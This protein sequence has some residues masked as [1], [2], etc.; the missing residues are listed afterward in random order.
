MVR[1]GKKKGYSKN[2]IDENP[3]IEEPT[4]IRI[5]KIID[6]FFQ[7]TDQVYTFEAGLTNPERAVVHMLCR[8]RGLVS[9]STGKGKQRR[10]SICKSKIKKL[11]ARKE[12]KN[13]T[14]LA[15]SEETKEVLRDLFTR[16]PPSD[17][18]QK[19]QMLTDHIREVD[20]KLRKK[21]DSFY[22]PSMS[23]AEIAKEMKA[24]AF[25][26]KNTPKLRQIDGERSKLPIASFREAI[27]STIETNQ[28]VL[29]SGETG[30]GKTTQ[31]PQYLLDYMWGKGEA[32]K[33][34]CTQP[35]RISATS[36]A[37]RISYERGEKV[38]ESIGY[39]I[40]LETKGGKRSSI[41][42]CTNGILLRVLVGKGTND[43]KTASEDISSKESIFGVTHII[44]RRAPLTSSSTSGKFCLELPCLYIEQILMSATL[45]AERFSQYFGGCPVIRVPGFTHPVKNF[46]LEDILSILK[47]SESN[48]LDSLSPN[49]TVQGA[50]LTEDYTASLDEA[51]NLA[52]SSDEFD[53]LLELVSSE[54]TPRILNYQD[55][56]NGASPL[57]VFAG[58]GNV[59]DVCMLLSL[60]A[61]CN[62][63]AKDGKTAVEWAQQEN[64]GEVVEVI[65]SHLQNVVSKSVEEY[66]LL[67]K[68]LASVNPEHIDIILIERL[69]RK[70]C[71]D[72]DEGA[73]LIFLPGWDDINKTRERLLASPFFEDTSKFVIIA[74]H[75]MVPSVEQKKVFKRPPHG[76]RKIILST[77]IA[78][79]AVT[80]DDVVYVIDSGRMKEKSYDPYSNV[81]TLH[82]SWVSKASAKQREGRAGRC[83][84]GI[85]YHLYSKTRATSL[86]EFQV[87]EI[88]RMPIEEL[89]LQV[90][91]L[92]PNCRIVDF[93]QK[94]LDPP[95][96]ETIRNAI[97][98]LQDIGALSPD[99]GLTELGEKLGSLPVH[100]ST[101]K[102]LF[103][104]ILMNCLEPA[105]T[106]ACASDYRDPFIL[107]MVPNEK[108]KALAAKAELASLYGGHSD[109]LMV[110]AA[111]DCW[112]RAKDKGQEAQF[113]SEYFVSSGTMNMLSSMRMQ[114]QRELIHTGFMQEDASQC[115]LNARDPGILHAVLVAGLYPMVGRLLPPLKSG[116]RVVVETACGAKVRLH[117]HSSNFKLSFDQSNSQPLVIYDEITRGDG[118]MYIRNCSIVGPYPLLIHATEMVVAPA[119]DNED[120][121]DDDCDASES[122]E[123]GI[124]LNTISGRQEER[125]MSSPDNTVSVVIDRWLK[126]EST[127]LDVA[128]IYCLRER[129]RAAI[130]FKVKYP[131]KVLP[132]ALGASMYAIACILSYDGLSGISPSLKTIGS[133]TSMKNATEPSG[134]D[135]KPSAFLRSLLSDAPAPP[136]TSPHYHKPRQMSRSMHRSGTSKPVV[137]QPHMQIGIDP[138]QQT[139][140]QGPLMHP[141]YVQTQLP[142]PFMQPIYVP[143]GLYP[144]QRT[145]F[146]GQG[147]GGHSSGG[148]GR[149][150]SFKRRRGTGPS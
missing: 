30:C 36:V 11:R 106:L 134:T 109:Q 78:E 15:F 128:Q 7:G 86:P 42:F 63:C 46:Y 119:E 22:K 99:E 47:S 39:K 37:E 100:P 143:I 44:V 124:E 3:N 32:C 75:S 110:I 122:D 54:A 104:A 148:Y 41:M 55:S 140:F 94:T 142:G 17:G 111:Y 28:V 50:D 87:P 84:P 48:H 136:E 6:D 113:C 95:I 13:V 147:F 107:P 77:N 93:L 8:K 38:G 49:D 131:S 65:K 2:Q 82:S 90:K 62:L 97:L 76:S 89:C 105:L 31:V 34:I 123:D 35:R 61:D 4:L 141:V 27:T 57:M 59:S 18:E 101:S 14:S 91:L 71:T 73:V 138:Y 98:V 10:V 23:K 85:C 130:L 103:F 144:V 72:S 29:I 9:K 116:R 70:I 133:L 16:Y 74:L 88:K 20:K 145:Q 33:I 137:E 117:P 25:R 114:L 1:S 150:D 81:S 96:S 139:H 26:T 79:T 83:Q 120:E 92:D 12:K 112:K 45:D 129:L 53:P 40:R 43:S 108:K 24:L 146:K 66:D 127:A 68:Y 19:G 149:T 115:S 51:I 121:S 67:E 126:F 132:P 102:M 125:I 5:S 69:L 80:I 118:G 52:W 58:K 56:L 135:S 60:G 64:Q 21:D